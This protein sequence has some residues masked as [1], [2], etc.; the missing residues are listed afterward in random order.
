MEMGSIA[1]ALSNPFLIAETPY[2]REV[3]QGHCC[4]PCYDYVKLKVWLAV[5]YELTQVNSA[6]IERGGTLVESCS[7]APPL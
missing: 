4:A 3:V 5:L 2:R 1:L 6:S 7:F